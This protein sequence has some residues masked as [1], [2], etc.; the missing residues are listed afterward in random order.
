MA[1]EERPAAVPVEEEEDS[2]VDSAENEPLSDAAAASE[3]QATM[4]AEAMQ[5]NEI[6]KVKE[7]LNQNPGLVDA[8]IDA[9]RRTLLMKA[10][11]RNNGDLV[12]YL[13]GLNANVDTR[14][15]V[16][17]GNALMCAVDKLNDNIFKAI[18]NNMNAMEP[19]D[20]DLGGEC[21][22][23]VKND[24][25]YCGKPGAEFNLNDVTRLAVEVS[26]TPQGVEEALE[27]ID[28]AASRMQSK[29]GSRQITP[30]V[31]A[32]AMT[33]RE[34]SEYGAF[35]VAGDATSSAGGASF[36]TA[37]VVSQV[38]DPR[39]PLIAL[40][41]IL[42]DK[43]GNELQ[44]ISAENSNIVKHFAPGLLPRSMDLNKLNGNNDLDRDAA[45]ARDRKKMRR[46]FSSA[47]GRKAKKM[48]KRFSAEGIVPVDY[49]QRLAA[50]KLH[51]TWL[52][53]QDGFSPRGSPT[54]DIGAQ[55]PFPDGGDSTSVV[56]HS[57]ASASAAS[58]GV[59]SAVGARTNAS[60]SRIERDGFILDPE[61]HKVGLFLDLHK[62]Q[63]EVA[64]IVFKLETQAIYAEKGAQLKF[65]TE[66]PEY[67]V[68]ERE[69]E[70][71]SYESDRGSQAAGKGL[72]SQ[73]SF[74]TTRVGSSDG[75]SLLTGAPESLLD[76]RCP[77]DAHT[78]FL[79]S[80]CRDRSS[81]SY[82][83][84][85]WMAHFDWREAEHAAE[86]DFAGTIPEHEKSATTSEDDI[87]QELARRTCPEVCAR[88]S[89]T[90]RFP[91]LL[92]MVFQNNVTLMMSMLEAK[93]SPDIAD[94]EFGIT[95][96]GWAARRGFDLVVRK[97]VEQDADVNVVDFLG[98]SPLM[99]AVEQKRLKVV[100]YLVEN[101]A[102]VNF[103]N[104][105]SGE[106]VLWECQSAEMLK[107]L[108]SHKI[109]MNWRCATHKGTAL[110]NFAQRRC[111]TKMEAE[112]IF[113]MVKLLVDAR[114]DVLTQ[115]DRCISPLFAAVGNL[116]NGNLAQLFL[117]EGASVEIFHAIC[118][119]A[120]L[121]EE[122][123]GEAVEEVEAGEAS[124]DGGG[125]DDGA[126]GNNVL[127]RSVE[128]IDA[129]SR[130]GRRNPYF[131]SEPMTFEKFSQLWKCV[132][133]AEG[134]QETFFGVLDDAFTRFGVPLV[135]ETNPQGKGQSLDKRIFHALELLLSRDM[136]SAIDVLFDSGKTQYMTMEDF[137]FLFKCTQVFVLG[138]TNAFLKEDLTFCDLAAFSD[139]GSSAA[140]ESTLSG[141]AGEAA[142]ATL[143]KG[144][145][146]TG[147]TLQQL[148]DLAAEEEA[149]LHALAN[150]RKTEQEFLGLSREELLTRIVGDPTSINRNQFYW[151]WL[152]A[153]DAR[154]QREL[155]VLK[156][157]LKPGEKMSDLLKKYGIKEEI[158]EPKIRDL[159]EPLEK[160]APGAVVSAIT[161]RVFG[162]NKLKNL[163]KRVGVKEFT[164][165]C[166]SCPHLRRHMFPHWVSGGPLGLS[167]AARKS[168]KMARQQ[169][170]R[171][172]ET[173]CDEKMT[174]DCH[175]M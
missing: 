54:E 69:R 74:A 16:F 148:M 138:V 144:V 132:K 157:T 160:K 79:V 72:R 20:F 70:K 113:R 80:L 27:F 42:L 15:D 173:L 3:E 64:S 2:P 21:S 55:R 150:A 77:F 92:K 134:M 84:P 171:T 9:N 63:S 86:E 35:Q 102:D 159:I 119:C 45:R 128:D 108:L 24:P 88:S 111:R 52:M 143:P 104:P 73:M 107:L 14:L 101:K 164:E 41:A 58:A 97:L 116:T 109:D 85:R 66:K 39:R 145:D 114:A 163:G 53:K 50:R 161:L 13:L 94:V 25:G 19:Y 8:S 68:R 56:S 78:C 115:D 129:G 59:V 6:A 4:L 96:I 165:L 18:M 152:D 12:S 1:E 110:L 36:S 155:D 149:R 131:D 5:G 28:N 60:A 169:R 166:D 57:C 17:R 31:P 118:G 43:D 81:A 125:S 141:A 127:E 175:V 139:A 82:V 30:R 167:K 98:K 162:K 65:F 153:E 95:P 37:H 44:R 168:E 146:T 62:L 136:E 117:Q 23:I 137:V 22:A 7:I 49:E 71:S 126:G 122:R 120:N 133:L 156:A 170:G 151:Q 121:N 11:H 61:R 32:T 67:S 48:P 46:S 147:M 174:S 112:E 154:K 103:I 29:V 99:A 34:D 105:R 87:F 123:L 100:R 51:E 47:S 140:G 172:V 130:T 135:E 142:G 158:A 33:P 26:L 89:N 75:N 76:M 38:V 90:R 10:I 124:G 40:Q 93:A 83:T 91:V 106:G